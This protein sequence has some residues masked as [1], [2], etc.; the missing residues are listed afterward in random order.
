MADPS[1]IQPYLYTTDS[2]YQSAWKDPLR[3]SGITRKTLPFWFHL[4]RWQSLISRNQIKRVSVRLIR[5]LTD[6]TAGYLRCLNGVYRAMLI[7]LTSPRVS[8]STILFLSSPL[9]FMTAYCV[10]FY[11]NKEAR[12]HPFCIWYKSTMMDVS[13]WLFWFSV[14]DC[15]KRVFNSRLP[16]TPSSVQL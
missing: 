8:F 2:D 9:V 16:Y 7:W 5:W 14:K 11:T 15:F 3:R 1:V 12:R 4:V 10:P 13:V 6:Q